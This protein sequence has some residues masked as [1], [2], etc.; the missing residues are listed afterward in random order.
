MRIQ[1]YVNVNVNA[2]CCILSHSVALLFRSVVSFLNSNRWFLAWQN[3]SCTLVP[4]TS[5]VLA[6]L[7]KLSVMQMWKSEKHPINFFSELLSQVSGLFWMIYFFYCS[8]RK[9]LNYLIID[10][11]SLNL[12]ID[13]DKHN[14][15]Q[16]FGLR[17]KLA[18]ANDTQQI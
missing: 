16:W 18:C 15:A 2:F 4:I 3:F 8:L 17:L 13:L 14:L 12:I 9:T 6:P 10:P 1:R 5:G 7:K 11:I